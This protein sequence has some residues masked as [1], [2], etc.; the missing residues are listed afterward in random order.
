VTPGPEAALA[1]LAPGAVAAVRVAAT[2]AAAETPLPAAHPSLVT[3]V[4]GSIRWLLK[5]QET[6]AE[7]QL[8]PESLGTVQIKLR[9]EGT[10]VHAR[11]WASDA[12]ALPVLQEHRAFLEASLREQGLSLGSFD[13]HQGRQG[14]E[15][16]LPTEPSQAAAAFRGTPEIGQETPIPAGPVPLNPH[17][18][19]IVA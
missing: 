15:T 14:G 18:I 16:P 19:E 11:V 5:N 17:R 9:V 6:G 12:S 8:H 7:L 13:L 3:Q 10:E 1:A 2:T 4:D